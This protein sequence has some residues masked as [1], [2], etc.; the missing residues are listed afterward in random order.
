VVVDSS[1]FRGY[2][3]DVIVASRDFLAKHPEVVSDFVGCYF[4]AAHQ[5]RDNMVQL[6]LTDARRLGTPLTDKQAAALVDGIWWKNTQ[7]NFAHF[8]LAGHRPL[9]HIEDII[10]NITNVLVSTG[11]MV[12]DPTGGRPN[13]MYYDR[14]LA[15]LQHSNF[16][17]G[18][19]DET[20]R[21]D[22]IELP[23]L[24]DAQWEQLV[25]VG[26]LEVPPLVFARGTS[27]LT[28]ASQHVLADLVTK[29]NTWPQYYVL[30][31]GN[32]SRQ[33]DLEA[34]QAL[35]EARARAA[36][37]QLIGQG[38]SQNRVRALGVE[39]SG[40]TSVSFMLGEMPY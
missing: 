6:V 17:P 29:L 11:G 30:I 12:A 36:E 40:T 28:S 5:L 32:A 21:D 26:T 37:Q 13:V 27:R 7:E 20:I 9:Q 24:T 23:A 31:R 14:I 4:R 33:G 39:P 35:A 19:S 8:G 3:V 10:S 18:L 15:Q 1:R 22:T 34:N 38:I 16:H 2:I 25:P